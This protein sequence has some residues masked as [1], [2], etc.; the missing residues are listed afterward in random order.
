MNSTYASFASHLWLHQQNHQ[1]STSMQNPLMFSSY[2][3]QMTR[4]RNQNHFIVSP[5]NKEESKGRGLVRIKTDF[6]SKIKQDDDK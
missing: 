6:T 5:Q 3:Y 2:C 1:A 4:T